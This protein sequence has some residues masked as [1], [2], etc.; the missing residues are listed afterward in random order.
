MTDDKLGERL[1]GINSQ[2]RELNDHRI[3]KPRVL[4]NEDDPTQMHITLPTNWIVRTDK[5]A[6]MMNEPNDITLYS[7]IAVKELSQARAQFAQI[8]LTTSSLGITSVYNHAIFF[9]YYESVIKA[10]L[11]AFSTVEAFSNIFLPDNCQFEW[12]KEI[13]DR[14]GVERRVPTDVKLRDIFKEAYDTPDFQSTTWWQNFIEL[15]AL[16][17]EVI[18]AKPSTSEERYSKLLSE[19]VFGWIECHKDLIQFFASYIAVNDRWL[20]IE[21][22]YGFGK[23]NL[24]PAFMSNTEYRQTIKDLYNPVGYKV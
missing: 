23:D 4:F 22:P 24:C 19:R 16:R 14:N 1:Q 11:T 21:L 15:K 6:F 7:N 13:L 10:V 5:A 9:D 20:L 8:K 17:D 2:Y 12:R 3:K 18:H